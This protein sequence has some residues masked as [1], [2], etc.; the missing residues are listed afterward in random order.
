M[1]SPDQTICS[2]VS[3]G[4]SPNTAW[5][6]GEKLTDWQFVWKSVIY[7]MILSSKTV[8]G[9]SAAPA[10]LKL[11]EPLLKTEVECDCDIP[12][13]GKH[14]CFKRKLTFHDFP[15][16]FP[17]VCSFNFLPLCNLGRIIPSPNTNLMCLRN[18]SKSQ[19]LRDPSRGAAARSLIL[20]HSLSLVGKPMKSG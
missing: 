4:S 19:I 18:F 9:T 13:P 3:L 11:T 6:P 15:L 14:V 20:P 17:R 2:D 7:Y 8:A 16:C 10:R 5:K 12:I 1:L